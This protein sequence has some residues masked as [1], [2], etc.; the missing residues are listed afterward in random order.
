MLGND[1][2]RSRRLAPLAYSIFAPRLK[3]RRERTAISSLPAAWWRGR[4]ALWRATQATNNSQRSQAE[5]AE[6]Q[7]HAKERHER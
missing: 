2:V 7:R 1:G 3:G 5:C 6:T 4:G